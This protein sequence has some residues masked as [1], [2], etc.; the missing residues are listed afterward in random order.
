MTN[1]CLKCPHQDHESNLVYQQGGGYLCKP[2]HESNKVN[3]PSNY[4]GVK[5]EVIEV[6]EAFGLGFNLGNCIKYILRAGKKDS[7]L[8]DLQK[9][10]WYLLREICKLEA[11]SEE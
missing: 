1:E 7:K 6:I 5:M 2:C 3:H 10:Q 9:A 4:Q 11:K 8:Q